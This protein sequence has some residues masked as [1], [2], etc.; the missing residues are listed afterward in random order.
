MRK[1]W[2]NLSCLPVK[3]DKH[4]KKRQ[5]K[6]KENENKINTKQQNEQTQFEELTKQMN[7]VFVKIQ[8]EI[9]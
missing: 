1:K 6:D 9:E 7:D 4:S 8:E 5:T 2:R 3:S